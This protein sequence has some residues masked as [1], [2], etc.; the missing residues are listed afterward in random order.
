MKRKLFIGSSSEGLAIAKQV[1]A[2]IT[3][4][5]GDWLECEI[6]HEGKVFSFNKSFLDS[7]VKASRRYDYGI[8]IATNDDLTIIRKLFRKVPRDNVVFE[9][10][11]FLGSLGLT[12][13]FLFADKNSKLPSDYNGITIPKFTSK[14]I[15]THDLAG[16]IKQLESTKNTFSLKVIP[17]AALA[18]G[19]FDN[20]IMLFS[21]NMISEKFNLKIILPTCLEDINTQTDIYRINNP[22]DSISIF[23]D[24][25]RP[26]ISRLKDDQLQYW[27]IPSTLSTLCKLINLV[28]PSNEIG[29]SP[30]KNEWFEY[31]LRNFK[32]SLEILISGSPICKDKVSVE[33]MAK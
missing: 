17:S 25:S 7:L 14:K 22:S 3:T 18:L 5:C 16:V 2:I 27:D 6:W 1:K 24:G 11:L 29:T 33:W 10:G 9:M 28:V 19:Y 4:S 15:N 31:E 8:L 26:V 30:E 20:F 21:K 23:N 32:G 12:R 13:A